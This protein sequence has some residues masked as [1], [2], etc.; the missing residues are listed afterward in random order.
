[1]TF[2][3]YDI[4]DQEQQLNVPTGSIAF[5]YCQIPVVYFP[6]GKHKIILERS[7]GTVETVTGLNL[8]KLSSESV[9]ARDGIIKKIEVH[10]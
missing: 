2:T 1:M 6:N 5:T 9:F 10:Y 4:A 7:N 8:G 3:Y